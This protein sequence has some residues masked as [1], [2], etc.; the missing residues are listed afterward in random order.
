MDGGTRTGAVPG[1]EWTGGATG[2]RCCRLRFFLLATAGKDSGVRALHGFTLSVV[3]A[4][5]LFGAGE[6][7]GWGPLAWIA[8]VPLLVAVLSAERPR[9][10]WSYGLVFGLVYFGVELSWIFLFGWMAWT[11]LCVFLAVEVSIGALV[12]G[13]LRRSRLAPLLIAGALTGVELFKDRWPFGGYSWGSVGTTQGSVP[14]VRWLTGVIGVYGL[15]FLIM[16]TATAIA[17]FIVER[18][19]AW[20]S[21][22]VAAGVLIVFVAVDLIAFSPQPGRGLDVAVVQGNVPRPVVSGQRDA[23]LRNHIDAT[24]EILDNRRVDLVVWP[25]ESVGSGVSPGA[26]ELVGD[27]ARE[28]STPLLVGQTF[29][30]GD[31]FLNVVRHVDGRGRL[32]DTYQKRHPVPFGEYVPLGFFR[33]FVGTLQS[34]IPTD[35]EPGATANVFDVH[36]SDRVT[37]IATPICFESVFPRD[38][39]D[40]AGNGA[41]LFVLS[42]NNASFERSYASEQ[43]IAH[44]RMRA[45]ETRQWVIQAAISGISAVISPDGTIAQSTELFTTDAFVASVRARRASS[46]YAKIGDL[47]P[48]LFAAASSVGLIAALLR[49]RPAKLESPS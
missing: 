1:A 36:G 23:I 21:I 24:R 19:V 10:A 38:F 46:L 2:R 47:F 20:T 9:R 22:A 8:L 16:L 29:V 15:S 12:A 44:T 4:L 27:L 31:R 32:V 30:D 33:R 41:E 11:G 49:R 28:L 7:L 42:T 14:G 48:A 6:P 17:W 37:K 43:H 13:V 5:L 34:Q 25:E 26:L 40:F 18:R 39:L 35:Q 3:S 45:L